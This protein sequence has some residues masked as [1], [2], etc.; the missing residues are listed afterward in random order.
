MFPAHRRTLTVP[1]APPATAK[2]GPRFGQDDAL[3]QDVKDVERDSFI[4]NGCY[5]K[6]A[7]GYEVVLTTV[8]DALLDEDASLGPDTAHD[9]AIQI[10]RLANRT[11]SGGDAYEAVV[12]MLGCPALVVIVADSE[13]AP[14]INITIGVGN[15]G[16]YW[17]CGATVAASTVYRILDA[18]ATVRDCVCS[19]EL[20]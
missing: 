5:V 10:L 9:M 18:N 19:P 7:S 2:P 15:H 1:M 3:K 17:G 12:K 13:L 11:Q 8:A 6:G 20:C 14:P 4:V 16:G